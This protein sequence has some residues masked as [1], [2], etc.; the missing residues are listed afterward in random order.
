MRRGEHFKYFLSEAFFSLQKKIFFGT[1]LNSKRNINM[2]LAS[3]D[4]VVVRA[5]V[6]VCA[7]VW[8]VRECSEIEEYK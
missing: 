7:C 2:K 1:I 6:C 4:F 8:C 3:L 5:S